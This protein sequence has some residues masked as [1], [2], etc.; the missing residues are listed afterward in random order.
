MTRR[1]NA[2]GFRLGITQFWQDTNYSQDILVKQYNNFLVRSYI[3]SCLQKWKASVGS[4][5]S[6]HAL[7]RTLVKILFFLKPHVKLALLLQKFNQKYNNIV[8]RK[9][10]WKTNY[11]AYAYP[12]VKTDV[13]I[14]RYISIII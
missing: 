8:T 9:I 4:I 10:Q 1:I 3:E 2:K 11:T 7:N 5:V 13:P 6:Y 14:E 12:V